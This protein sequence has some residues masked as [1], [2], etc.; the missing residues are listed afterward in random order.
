MRTEA[1]L[2]ALTGLISVVVTST[3]VGKQTASLLQPTVTLV[4]SDSLNM[5]KTVQETCFQ[6][7]QSYCSSSIADAGCFAYKQMM[8]VASRYKVNEIEHMIEQELSHSLSDTEDDDFCRDL[9]KTVKR[10]PAN[11][12]SRSLEPF[13]RTP[14]CVGFCYTKD[15]GLAD[16]CRALFSGYKLIL[17]SVGKGENKPQPM[18]A[19]AGNKLDSITN[20]SSFAKIVPAMEEV[21]KPTTEE[22]KDKAPIPIS[23]NT[24]KFVKKDNTDKNTNSAVILAPSSS[25]ISQANK[26]KSEV[27]PVA[28][29]EPDLEA[30]ILEKAPKEAV[31]IP[32]Q[33]PQ[34]AALPDKNEGNMDQ[35]QGEIDDAGGD[36]AP[37]DE[38]P[39]QPGN[40]DAK[41]ATQPGYDNSDESD[42]IASAEDVNENGDDLELNGFQPVGK[43]PAV[44]EKAKQDDFAESSKASDIVSGSDPFYDQKD[45]NFFSYFLFAMFSCAMLYVAYHNKSKLLALVVEGRRTSSGRGGFSKGR[46]HTAAYRKLDSNLEEAITSGSGTSGHSSSQIIY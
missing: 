19:P 36:M 17:Q 30:K 31:H 38:E 22:I 4:K 40:Q 32:E 41:S 34:D 2:L 45:S 26:P 10:L 35:Q 37:F 28:V 29:G 20:Q 42:G 12:F 39:K 9:S 44:P 46:K 33:L 25:D 3:L 14:T 7:L 6:R 27:K 15:S 13:K 18:E 16:V 24:E 23:N 11:L 1:I 5:S 21:K 43:Q 8:Q